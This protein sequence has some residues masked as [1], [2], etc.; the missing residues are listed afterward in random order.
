MANDNKISFEVTLDEKSI[1]DAYS[2]LE[3]ESSKAGKKV[4]KN[5]DESVGDKLSGK[6]KDAGDNILGIF[7]GLSSKLTLTF[8]AA[9]AGAFA[10]K[11]A[12]D[13]TF[14]GEALNQINN[15]FE[16]LSKREGVVSQ[17]LLAGL[18]DAAGGLIDTTDLLKIANKGLVQF[19]ESAEK[20]P[21]ILAIAKQSALIFGGTA[22]EKFE[23]I[24][25]AIANGSTKALKNAG[26]IVDTEKV[27]KDF[28][29]SIGLVAGELTQA[30]RQQALLNAVL[31]KGAVDFEGIDG[32]ASVA[33]Q[34][35]K[36]LSVSITNIMETI[37]MLIA[38]TLGP[39][40][41][42]VADTVA[43]LTDRVGSSI[44]E[45][46]GQKQSVNEATA[47]LANYT[48]Q[49]ENLQKN[50]AA[51]FTLDDKNLD[52]SI[53]QRADF[54][55]GE[56]SKLS[57]FVQTE[58]QKTNDALAAQAAATQG[59][60][61]RTPEQLR[62]IEQRRNA[63][64]GFI[65][66]QENAELQSQEKLLQFET[67]F[68]ARRELTKQLNNQKLVLLEQDFKNK[69][70]EID[71]QFSAE[72]GFNEQ[73]R[74]AASLAVTENFNK[75]RELLELTADEERVK[76]I[77]QTKER[78]NIIQNGINNIFA[79]G[80]V[81]LGESLTKGGNAFEEFGK[82]IVGIIA[83]Q[84]ITLGQA[85]IIQ[86]LAIETF[87]ASINTLLPGS[88][89]AA[90]AAG[91]GLVLFGTALKAAV[92]GGGGASSAGA[93]PSVTGGGDF[94]GGGA[95]EITGPEDLQPQGPTTAINVNVQGNILDRR[96]SGLEIAE[97]LQEAF[98]NQ[99]I[100]IGAAV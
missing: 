85:L 71:K 36:R 12:L 9:A 66:S 23:E 34:A 46:T 83:D 5:F 33:T 77:Q 61:I 81:K 35:F 58:Q 30:Q 74:A 57:A 70:A 22:T 3:D 67:D 89:A 65:T 31:Q 24:S 80:A 37:Q 51:G 68:G 86:G 16:A 44:K 97:V 82:G 75:Q 1:R 10:F 18:E 45:L 72:N 96:Q 93:A 14:E 15:Q 26:I 64:Q 42:K 29:K 48:K 27:Y 6:F 4:A 39:L 88:G 56:I 79:Q 98:S 41:A 91:L 60:D 20:L 2:K 25:T 13:F 47:S 100:S 7:S 50:L 40:F 63:L 94:G 54:L 28:A 78:L 43:M 8:A 52:P 95:T 59:K 92:G 62:A 69:L 90:A 21:G 73:Q 53:K 87:V 49:L 99:G 55:K 11:K 76:R 84:I 38:N 32:K 17:A 19:G